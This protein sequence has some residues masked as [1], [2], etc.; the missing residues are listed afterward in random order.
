MQVTIYRKL[1]D[2]RWESHA[3][4]FND[5]I[6]AVEILAGYSDELINLFLGW[7]IE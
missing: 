6:R 4:P 1:Q 2:G 7:K 5:M 3:G